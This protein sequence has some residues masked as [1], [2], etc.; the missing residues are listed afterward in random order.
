VIE[1]D[2]GYALFHGD[3][4]QSDRKPLE[5]SGNSKLS[6]LQHMYDDPQLRKFAPPILVFTQTQLS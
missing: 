6:A 1:P 4:K 5:S 3:N 2:F